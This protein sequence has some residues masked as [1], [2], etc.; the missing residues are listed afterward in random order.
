MAQAKAAGEEPK[1]KK[2]DA[3]SKKS[4]YDKVSDRYDRILKRI[5]EN[6]TEDVAALFIKSIS[7]AYD[8]HSEYFSQ[9]QYDNFRIGMNK[10]LTGIGAM[11]QKNED[12]GGAT[13]EG[14]VVGGPAFKV[15]KL[16]VS[17]RVIGVAPAGVAAQQYRRR[18]ACLG[19]QHLQRPS[20]PWRRAG[21]HAPG[22]QH[23]AAAGGRALAVQQ[24]RAC[25]L[26]CGHEAAV[27]ALDQ[28]VGAKARGG[29][30]HAYKC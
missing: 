28:Q 27:Q 15:G 8:P 29:A 2:D 24:Q 7:A 14:L 21:L 23:P 13:I 4:I 22:L 20:R 30:G 6:T 1:P 10:S 26:L 11:L 19:A 9:Q 5:K 25:V 3:E 17:D 18:R 16:E 12:E